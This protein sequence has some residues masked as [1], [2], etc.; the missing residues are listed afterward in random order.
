MLYLSD[1]T[2]AS[3]GITPTEIADALEAAISEKAAGRLFT[4]PKS[5]ILPGEGRYMMSTLAVGNAQDLTVLKQVS[6]CPENPGR[7]LPAINGAIMALD[8]QKGLLKAV[9]DANWVTAVRTA[10]LS[11]VAARRLAKPDAASVGFIG[12]GVQ[13]SSHLAAFQDLFP[14]E[15]V[16]VFG[17]GQ[18]NIDR[19]CAEARARGLTATQAETP[20]DAIS[21]VDLVVTS[22]TLNYDIDPFLDATWLKPGAFASITDL[23]IPWHSASLSAFGQI[24]VDDREQETASEV[25]MVPP[26]RINADLTELVSG[27][28]PLRH[29]P[30]RPSAFAFRGI[31]LGDYAATA[32]ALDRAQA[33]GFGTTM[34]G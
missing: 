2:L 7:G 10:G 31:A 18:A 9:L 33:G 5:A 1:E 25:K 21:D 29:D 16:T 23:G 17:R 3:M 6:V 11:A 34:G 19:F 32:L 20:R 12:S 8:A 15:R 4:T 27:A 28:H 24:V 30:D 13:A 14:L 26:D 22:V